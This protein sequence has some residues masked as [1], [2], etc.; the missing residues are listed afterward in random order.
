MHK[1]VSIDLH[2][3][4]L[5]ANKRLASDN[6]DH[7][8]K[9]NIIA[10]DFLGSIGSGKT[11]IIESIS[12]ILKEKNTRV[13]VIAGDVAGDDD[14]KRYKV[15]SL[16][17][18]NLN[19]G[20]ECH[21]DAH[22]VQHAIDNLNLDDIDILLIENVGNLVCPVDFPLGTQKRI[23][24]ISVTEGDDIVRKHP[25]IFREADVVAINKIDLA[26]I[27]EVDPKKLADDVK[28]INSC[29]ITILTDAKHNVGIDELIQTLEI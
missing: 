28:K 18:V 15:H 25:H 5:E 11:L 13:G 14:Y 3:D 29:A 19:T 24:V 6:Q 17:V 12:D 22:L 20:K 9:H 26:E 4:V 7:L 23:I 2:E 1:T 8:S 10:F 27:M 21:L 16:P